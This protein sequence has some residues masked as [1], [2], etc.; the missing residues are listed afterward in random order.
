MI[1]ATTWTYGEDMF[2]VGD[3]GS[4]LG[5]L[6]FLNRE[7]Y[8]FFLRMVWESVSEGSSENSL[9]DSSSLLGVLSSL[10]KRGLRL[11]GDFKFGS[12]GCCEEAMFEV[13]K[14]ARVDGCEDC[15]V[16]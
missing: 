8:L 10:E 2:R 16:G 15:D 14:G 3:E 1:V 13:W 11:E 9:S 7:E 5:S 12:G 6:K 4:L